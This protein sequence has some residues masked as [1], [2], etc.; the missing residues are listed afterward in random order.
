MRTVAYYRVSTDRQGRSGLGLDAQREAVRV[1]LAGKGWP[2]V[3]EFTEIESG[4]RKDRP[5]LAEALEACRLYGA[6]LVIA[7]LDRLARNVAFVSA[8]MESGVDFVAADFPQANR[9][10]IHILAAV[11]E[12]EAEMVSKRTKAALAA[13]KARGQR[14]GGFRGYRPTEEDRAKAVAVRRGLAGEGRA[15]VVPVIA[16]IKAA[17]ATSLRAIAAELDARGVPAPRGGRWSATAVMRVA[18]S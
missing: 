16:A 9:L 6:T 7:K 2:P 15:R 14:L 4:K 18:G 11:A 3:V 8:L 5:K 17:G 13:A 10:T 1:F 12:H